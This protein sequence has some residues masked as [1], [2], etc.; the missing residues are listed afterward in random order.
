MNKIVLDYKGMERRLGLL[1]N[2]KLMRIHIEREGQGPFAGNV[3]NGIVREIV[4]G[5]NAAF[6]DIGFDKNAYLPFEETPNYHLDPEAKTYVKQGEKLLV[7]ILRDPEGTKGAKISALI[8]V[9]SPEIVYIKGEHF[10][11]TSKKA[12]RKTVQKWKHITA[13]NLQKDEGVIVRTSF[14]DADEESFISKLS[15]LRERYEQLQRKASKSKAPALISDQNRILNLIESWTTGTTGDLWTN[16][17]EG[18]QLLRSVLPE[19]WEAKLQKDKVGLYDSHGVTEELEKA[20]KK[21]VWL[22]NGSYL[23]FGKTEAM[24]VI[25]VNTGKFTGKHDINKTILD[26]NILAATE[27]GRQMILRNLSGIIVIDFINMKSP[28]H[29]H[30]VQ[31]AMETALKDDPLRSVVIGFTELGLMQITRKK[32]GPD[33]YEILQ[34]DCLEC[35]GTGLIKSR[36]SAIYE[37]ERQLEAL[38]YS[39]DDSVWVVVDSSFYTYIKDNIHAVKIHIL[40]GTK[41]IFVTEGRMTGANRFEIRALGNKK[42]LEERLKRTEEGIKNK[43]IIRMLVNHD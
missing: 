10:V 39:L 5:M 38:K 25:D 9:S 42:D 32:E 17:A 13:K 33:L 24:H 34:E 8:E 15:E 36:Q 21:V 22:S 1:Q 20:V 41:N 37:L 19:T 26:T 14:L 2:D 11:R 12:D 23:L 3:Y 29:R 16:S 35:S 27:V 43:P 7:R 6:V 4:P 40:S 31:A 18:M 28:E 30:Q